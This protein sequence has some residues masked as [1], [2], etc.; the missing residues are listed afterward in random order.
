MLDAGVS[1]APT[2]SLRV[3]LYG[4][5]LLGEV[6]RRSHFD[7]TGLVESTY[8]PLKEGRVIGVEARWSLR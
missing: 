6:F 7:L 1:V 3:T 8:S 4:R 5:N 2:E